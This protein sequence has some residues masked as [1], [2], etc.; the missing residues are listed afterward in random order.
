MEV[1]NTPINS[2]VLI[3]STIAYGLAAAISTFDLRI[4]QAKR[5]GWLDSDKKYV[6]SWVVIFDFLMW[7]LWIFI[8]ILN[9]KYAL[10]LFVIKFILKVLPIL[11]YLGSYLMWPF[12][13]T[14]NANMLFEINAQQKQAGQKLRKLEKATTKEEMKNAI[15]SLK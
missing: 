14:E 5:N 8:F 11:E 7:G 6:P 13:G 2:L 15:D 12:I 10:L 9:W 3:L 4:E 1:F